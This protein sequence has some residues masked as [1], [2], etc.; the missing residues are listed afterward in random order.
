MGGKIGEIRGEAP[1]ATTVSYFKGNDPSQWKTNLATAELVNLG[2]VYEGI[3]LRLK[4]YGN[5]VEKLF[6]VKPGANPGQIKISLS[7]VKECGMRSAECGIEG[8]KSKIQ[9]YK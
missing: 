2:E 5:N 8:P 1:S 4:A 9:N 6:T 3:D 7:G